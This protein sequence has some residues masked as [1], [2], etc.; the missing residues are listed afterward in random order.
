MRTPDM[1]VSIAGIKFSNP[2]IAASGTFGFGREYEGIVDLDAIGGISLKGVTSSPRIGNPPPRIAETACG[3]LNSVGLQNPGIDA[4]IADILPEIRKYKTVLIANI[5][6]N[7]ASE[8][9][10]MCEKLDETDID[11]IEINLSCPNVHAGRMIFGTSRE[12]VEAVM[13]EARGRTKKPLIV[14]LTPNITDITEPARAAE[15]YGADAVSLIN[16]LMGMAIDLETRRPI[17]RNN[18]GGLSGPAVK[19]VALRMVNDCARAVRIPVIGMGGI[20]TGRDAL[21]FM[22]AGA[23]AVMAG[24]A[25]IIEPTACIRIAEEMRE[26]LV[27]NDIPCVRDMTHTLVLY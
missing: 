11:M 5:S 8:Y 4:F 24:T 23:S 17:L 18:T 9:A 25:N 14:K 2:V 16:T 1:S 13:R 15:A 10:G 6:G 19:P 12:G 27:Q 21:E 26:Y 22:V 7:T 3:M 20:T